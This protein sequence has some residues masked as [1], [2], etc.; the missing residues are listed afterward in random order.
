VGDALVQEDVG[1][2][3][4]TVDEVVSSGK[5]PKEFLSLYSAFS[6]FMVVKSLSDPGDLMGMPENSIHEGKITG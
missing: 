5:D 4:R 2:L 1:E 3:I 6:E